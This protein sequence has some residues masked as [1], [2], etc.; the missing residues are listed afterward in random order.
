MK[1]FTA[2]MLSALLML[3]LLAG[4]GSDDAA[5]GSDGDKGEELRELDVV[6]DWY[7]NALHAFLYEAI[8]KGYFA[9][10]GLKVNIRFPSNANDAISMVAA[11]KADIGL[12]YQQDV[13]QARA[14]QNVPVKSIGA[15]VQAPLNIILSLKE[16]N[17]TSP[18]D[19]VGKTV[20]Y[21]GTE[22]SEALIRSIMDNVGA[23]YSDVTMVDVGFDLMSS[24]TTGN[25]DATIGCLVNH[26]VPQMEEEGFAVNWFDL[27]DYGV[28]TYYEGVFLANDDAIEHD[29]DT[30][31]SFL[32]ACAKGF[33]DMQANPEEALQILLDNQNAENFPLSE[34]V[35]RKSMETL[36]PLM[37]TSD[38]AFLSQTDACWQE[39]ME[40]M[41]AQGLIAEAPSLDDVRVNLEF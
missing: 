37:E 15:V 13:I 11:G 39:N 8:D 30:L 3:S 38:A 40:W 21:A 19:L 7:P 2:L 10:E 27:D 1:R 9:E 29:A 12:Y 17:I 34:T 33:D 14:E 35:E 31:K 28:P 26:E 23:D 36:L 16:K 24:M 25:V 6:L 22:L 18:A 32:R 20:G 41:L 4:C 5:A